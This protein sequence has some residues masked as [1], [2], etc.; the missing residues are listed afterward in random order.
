MSGSREEDALMTADR[1]ML[2]GWG[3]SGYPPI[4]GRSKLHRA[5]RRLARRLGLLPQPSGF[6]CVIGGG[7]SD[8]TAAEL[9]SIRRFEKRAEARRG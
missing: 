7:S 9:E 1:S 6:S 5:R 4:A 8:H 2:P 3:F